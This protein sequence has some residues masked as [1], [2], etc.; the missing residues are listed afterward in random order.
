MQHSIV[1]NFEINYSIKR[2]PKN[3]HINLLLITD[4]NTD[5]KKFKDGYGQGYKNF[6]ADT[7]TETDTIFVIF[8]DTVSVDG[9]LY[10]PDPDFKSQKSP[11]RI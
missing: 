6:K 8:T 7:D 5:A 1:Y 9:Y 11:L 2:A 10:P 3:I 4:T